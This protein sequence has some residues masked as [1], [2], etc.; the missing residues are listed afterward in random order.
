MGD[1]VEKIEDPTE[2][3]QVRRQ[4]SRVQYKSLLAA[5]L[6]TLLALTLPSWPWLF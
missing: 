2:L 5:G 6:L 4:S 3:A 1:E